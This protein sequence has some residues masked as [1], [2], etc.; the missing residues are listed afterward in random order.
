MKIWY[1]GFVGFAKIVWKR[2]M[3]L[4]FISIKMSEDELDI[5]LKK[6]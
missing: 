4:K 6:L 3:N 2:F 5:I 1:Q